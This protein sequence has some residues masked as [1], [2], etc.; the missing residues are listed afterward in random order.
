MRSGASDRVRAR[1]RRI[2]VG[3]AAA[4]AE[5]EDV[6]LCEQ[7]QAEAA[8]DGADAYAEEQKTI[9]SAHEQGKQ[10]TALA[11]KETML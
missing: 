8:R 10:C 4:T 3:E 2:V 5:V 9:G 7:H 1:P 6:H 11:S